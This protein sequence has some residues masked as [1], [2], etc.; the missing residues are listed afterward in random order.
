MLARERAGY[1]TVRDREGIKPRNA[2]RHRPVIEGQLFLVL[3]QFLQ[4]FS[5]RIGGEVRQGRPGH[6]PAGLQRRGLIAIGHVIVEGHAPGFVILKFRRQN[7][8]VIVEGLHLVGE[9][10]AGRHVELT[11]GKADLVKRGQRG[12]IAETGAKAA[13]REL[14]RLGRR[15]VSIKRL[16]GLLAP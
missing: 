1:E 12:V 10:L 15:S 11:F 9:F 3:G 13:H 6:N 16:Q 5:F 8:L 2:L 7:V 14:D 4:P